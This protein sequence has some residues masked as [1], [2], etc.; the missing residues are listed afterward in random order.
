M[1]TKFSTAYLQEVF[2]FP[3][4]DPD[5]KKKLALSALMVLL[6]IFLVPMIF[7]WGYYY[8]LMQGIIVNKKLASLPKWD[9]WG[10]L[11]T[12]GVKVFFINLLGSLPAIAIVVFSFIIIMS[13]ELVQPNG[14]ETLLL[15]FPVFGLS[16]MGIVTILS[17]SMQVFV[18]IAISHMVAKNE[19]AAAFRIKEWWSIFRANLSGF[20]LAFLILLGVNMMIGVA[21][22]ILFITI[23][24]IC[25]FPL[26]SSA[27]SAYTLL[28]KG[29]LYAQVYREA[30]S[31]SEMGQETE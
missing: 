2:S 22:Q 31:K 18:P 26:V 4:R 20:V 23:I 3:F 13:P 27:I 8:R 21:T 6:G 11:F 29:A 19:F 28:I 17:L 5:W 10:A 12:D 25:I 16:G 30:V 9:D 15:L 7:F 1:A 14:D 24:L